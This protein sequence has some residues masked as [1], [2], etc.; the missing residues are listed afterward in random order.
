MA[1]VL[2]TLLI[3]FSWLYGLG[4]AA[5]NAVY[6]AG[7]IASQRGPVPV[8]SVGNLTAGGTGKTPLVEHIAS[9][10]AERGRTVAVVSLGYGRKT[11]GVV[12]VSNRGSVKAD[13]TTGGDEPVQIAR[14][15]PTLS[16]V[17]G[18][19]RIDA[20]EAAVRECGADVVVLDDAFQH[21]AIARDLDILVMDARKNPMREALLPAGMRREW[22]SGI[23]RAHLVGFSRSSPGAD[24]A[25]AAELPR[26]KAFGGTFAYRTVITR[27]ASFPGG[28]TLGRMSLGGKRFMAFSGIGDHSSFMASLGSEGIAVASDRRFRD[29]HVYT[30][31]DAAAICRRAKGTDGLITTEK[32]MVRLLA[33]PAVAH[34]LTDSAPV[35]YAVAGIEVIRG[36]ETLREAVAR[37]LGG[38]AGS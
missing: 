25:W 30:A 34:V 29:H 5:M 11:R 19:R 8:I 35:T 6:D 22:L 10:L 15:F 21:R 17:V 13:A 32:D 36:E 27:F 31:D 23:R 14:K 9:A 20:V 33:A 7:F 26:G 28:E 3:P 38:G 24:P 18:E 4:A 12:V 16:V 1:G 37:A 2:H